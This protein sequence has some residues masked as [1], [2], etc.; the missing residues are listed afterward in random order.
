VH[1][2]ALVFF[3]RFR[4]NIRQ[5]SYEFRFAL[6]VSELLTLLSATHIVKRQLMP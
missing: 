5:G 2:H 1:I 3:V 4:S 6:F